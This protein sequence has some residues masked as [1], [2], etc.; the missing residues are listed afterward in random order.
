MSRVLPAIEALGTIWLIEIFDV[1]DDQKARLIY[2]ET[3][4]FLT[5]FNNTYSRFRDDSLLTILN[6]QKQL[7]TPPTDL[8]A[9]LTLGQTW[10]QKTAGV[11]NIMVESE[12]VRRGYDAEYSFLEK[13]GESFALANP[14]TAINITPDAI[15]LQTGRIDLGGL[16]KGYAL[17]RV[18]Q[19]LRTL[20]IKYFLINGGGD[21]YATSDND[22][23]ITIYLEHPLT[24]NTYLGETTLHNEAFASSSPH[25]RRWP[26]Q[27]NQLTHL[28]QTNTAKIIEID[29]TY[30]K[31]VT[32]VEADILATTSALAQF[33]TADDSYAIV[34]YNA[35]TKQLAVSSAFSP[36]TVF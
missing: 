7:Q 6:N 8:V 2:D 17:D 9:M 19:L 34:R 4:S 18:A 16:G 10:Y 25:K 27:K 1:I 24:P 11:F 14:I 15:K 30:T 13:V 33:E 26:G 20:G 22:S 21:I 3:V 32:A 12:L 5:T 29:A 23:P 28:V 36:L 31:A 35:T